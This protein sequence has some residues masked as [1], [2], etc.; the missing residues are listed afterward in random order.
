MRGIES[1]IFQ[2]ANRPE[3]VGERSELTA[4]CDLSQIE[5]GGLLTSLKVVIKKQTDKL[6]DE[7]LDEEDVVADIDLSGNDIIMSV[8][9]VMYIIPLAVINGLK[10]MM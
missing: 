5:L 4:Y 1:K 2:R 8:D 10:S 3:A 7:Y 6:G 9:D